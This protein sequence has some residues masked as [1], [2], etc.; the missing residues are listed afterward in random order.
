MNI[1]NNIKQIRELKNFSQDF[2]AGEIEVS[3]ST[4]S[5]I[6][7]GSAPI[8]IDTLQRIADVLEVD[9]N[10]LLS[11]TNVFHFNKTAHQCGFIHHQTNNAL[12]IE[13]LR[14][15]IRDEITKM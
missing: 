1:G 2:V 7:S 13:M 6:E 9:L 10:T 4:Y 8:K 11:T 15:I 3:Q 14:K 12:D 5:R